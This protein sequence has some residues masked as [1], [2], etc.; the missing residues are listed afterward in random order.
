MYVILKL[1]F[2][3]VLFSPQLGFGFRGLGLGALN[4]NVNPKP[5]TLNPKP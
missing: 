3:F 5:S 2:V 4:V 1:P